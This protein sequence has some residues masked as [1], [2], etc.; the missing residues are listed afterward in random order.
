MGNRGN[1]IW[2]RIVLVA[3]LGAGTRML[4]SIIAGGYRNQRSSLITI[5]SLQIDM[6]S[7]I[8]R[9]FLVTGDAWKEQVSRQ[10]D[11]RQGY[12]SGTDKSSVRVRVS[13][14]HAWLNIKSATLGVQRTEY[15]YEIPLA[16]ALEM[17]E[18]FCAGAVIEKTRYYV[19]HQGHTWEVDVFAGANAGLVVAE[20]ELDD[21]NE[22]FVRPDWAGEEV[23]HDPRYYNVC[24]V[25]HPY[26]EWNE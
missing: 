9:K 13:D 15:D 18:N 6:A 19:P 20:I 12:L 17:L 25:S 16:D 1:W 8:E 4:R 23:S 10:A 24:L 11:Y 5:Y 22:A 26:S 3:M 2:S 21:E 7:E 14:S